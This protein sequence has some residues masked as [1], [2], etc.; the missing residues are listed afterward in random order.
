MVGLCRVILLY[1][2]PFLFDVFEVFGGDPIEHSVG[3]EL[4]GDR[5]PHHA[6]THTKSRPRWKLPKKLKVAIGLSCIK[7]KIFVFLRSSPIFCADTSNA[8][9]FTLVGGDHDQLMGKGCCGDQDVVDLS[10]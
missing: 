7:H 6:T 5:T 2:I 3:V 10:R 1:P 4:V 9:E 8:I